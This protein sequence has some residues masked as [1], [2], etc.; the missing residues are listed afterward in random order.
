MALF[1]RRLKAAVLSL[2]FNLFGHGH[3]KFGKPA[4]DCRPNIGIEQ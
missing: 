4:E 2:S 1:A 3:T